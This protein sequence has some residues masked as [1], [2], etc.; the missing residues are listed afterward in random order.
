ME[1]YEKQ[2]L[3][4]LNRAVNDKKFSSN[5]EEIYE[6]EKIINEAD[7][8]LISSLIYYSLDRDTLKQID[9][10]ILNNWKVNI[11]KSNISQI[12]ILNCAKEILLGLKEK[13][14]QVV[15]LKGF[16]LKNI[17][18][19]P[20]FR[21]MCDLDILIDIKDYNLVN[22]YLVSVGYICGKQKHPVHAV[23]C[24]ENGSEVE[25]HWKLIN[26]DY[27]NGDEKEFEKNIWKNAK[28]ITIYGLE[29]KTLSDED[30]LIHI[31][32]HMAVHTK[33]SGFGLRQLYD[34]ALFTKNKYEDIDWESFKYRISKYG[35]LT[36]TE[37]LYALCDKLFGIK[38]PLLY[39]SNSNL[40][41]EHI[42]LLLESIIYSGGN[43][44]RE[45]IIDF[46]LLHNPNNSYNKV[47]KIIQI[48]FLSRKK[49]SSNYS[50]AKKYFFL[51]PIA[52]IHRIF[53]AI[54]RKNELIRIFKY[55]KQSIEAGEKQSQ[56]LNMFNL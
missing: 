29:I 50:Y 19:R 12:H 13:G 27:Y 36:F 3:N 35:I 44:R 40:K 7:K 32:M 14:I 16:I 10:E 8:H 9:Y 48:I 17:Y 39:L 18:P 38:V 11:L 4:I 34:L 37:G 2:V 52:W 33:C 56:I 54:F 45:Q 41:E 5:N 21:T 6:W 30:F 28:E 55:T 42:N 20:E 15:V 22:K 51:L 31:C 1:L 47:K 26:K 46:T 43:G 53:R 23:Y 49:L 24:N 25:V